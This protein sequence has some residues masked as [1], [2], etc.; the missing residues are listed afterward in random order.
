MDFNYLVESKKKKRPT[1]QFITV[2]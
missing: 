1:R 2:I